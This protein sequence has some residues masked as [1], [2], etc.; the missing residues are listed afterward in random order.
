MNR[1]SEAADVAGVAK[2]RRPRRIFAV[3][4]LFLAIPALIW[5]VAAFFVARSLKYPAFLYQGNGQDVFGERVPMFKR[6]SVTDI[7]T[8]IGMDP[9]RY[10]A[11]TVADDPGGHGQVTV[12]RSHFP[13]EP[14]D[15]LLITPPAGATLRRLLLI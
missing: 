11:G 4:A 10:D 13:G 14:P 8:A 6:G 1:E 15:S 7:A 3:G 5:I 2:E 9:E 12:V